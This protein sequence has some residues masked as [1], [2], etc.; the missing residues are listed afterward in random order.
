MEQL[1]NSV[2]FLQQ[3]STPSQI[4]S[5]VSSSLDDSES[6]KNEKD[7]DDELISSLNELQEPKSIY[8]NYFMQRT[9]HNNNN[10]NSKF[11]NNYK[12]EFKHHQAQQRCNS[13]INLNKQI[14]LN[15]NHKLH[16]NYYHKTSKLSDNSCKKT[17][18]SKLNEKTTENLFKSEINLNSNLVKQP[19]YKEDLFEIPISVEKNYKL[20]KFPSSKILLTKSHANLSAR[21]VPLS[22]N[23]NNTANNGTNIYP[24]SLSNKSVKNFHYVY[25]SKAS[26]RDASDLNMNKRFLYHKYNNNTFSNFNNVN[27]D[28]NVNFRHRFGNLSYDGDQKSVKLVKLDL[29]PK[30]ND[31]CIKYL[32][33]FLKEFDT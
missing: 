3:S 25:K 9:D 21:N 11:N 30:L 15:N 31:N 12:N 24:S 16:N 23:H 4:T 18:L 7:A 26:P 14:I 29:R 2:H 19:K 8:D 22:Y 1:C 20:E 13:L 33:E 32:D 10:N 28:K 17:N 5:S 6:S 27:N